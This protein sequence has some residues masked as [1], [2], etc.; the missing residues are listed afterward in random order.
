[1]DKFWEYVVGYAFLAVI[2]GGALLTFSC[3]SLLLGR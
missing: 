3:G 1:M 2:V